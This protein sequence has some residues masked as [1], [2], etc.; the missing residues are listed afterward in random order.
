MITEFR[1]EY[2][3]LSNKYDAPVTI[4]GLTYRNAE[5]AYQAQKTVSEA[6]K[7]MFLNL[8]GHYAERLGKR[9]KIRKDWDI[10]KEQI[11]YEILSVKFSEKHLKEKLLSTGEEEIVY[12]TGPMNL[13]WGVHDGKGKNHLGRLLMKIRKELKESRS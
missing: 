5:S 2:E 10:S 4:D 12:S 1:N 11:L 8:D 13:F 7:K 9:I 6:E 3:F